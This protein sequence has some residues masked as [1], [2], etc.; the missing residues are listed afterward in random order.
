MILLHM[1]GHLT[2]CDCLVESASGCDSNPIRL[3]AVRSLSFRLA[4]SNCVVH[5]HP[6]KYLRLDFSNDRSCL[7]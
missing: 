4:L 1:A 7:A 3:L 2:H 6:S 5:T